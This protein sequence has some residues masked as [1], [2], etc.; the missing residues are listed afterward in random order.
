M[1][2]IALVADKRTVTCFKIAGLKDVYSVNN[3]EEAERCIQE[4]LENADFSIIL[5]T[6]NV[7][8]QMSGLFGKIIER[9]YPVIISIPDI[10]GKA[11]MKTDFMVEL[12]K[13]KT[14]IEV[15]LR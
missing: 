2:R 8:S 12:I 7:A 14:G 9:K 11:T 4:L 6:E 15:K 10:R 5:V 13:R 1:A 3:V